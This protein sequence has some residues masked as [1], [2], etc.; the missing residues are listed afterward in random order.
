MALLVYWFRQSTLQDLQALMIMIITAGSFGLFMIGFLSRRVDN[1]SAA[2]ATGL[3]V[4]GVS[5]WVF[6]QSDWARLRW[7]GLSPYLPNLF[8]LSVFSN[9]SLFALAW[10][11]ARLFNRRCRHSLTD[12]TIFTLRKEDAGH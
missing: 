12:L 9:V 11:I 4:A 1:F 2:W 6:L 3:T 8:W 7:P 5:L 10:L